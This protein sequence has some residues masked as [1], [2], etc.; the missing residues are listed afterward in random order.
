[1]IKKNIRVS[2]PFE[3]KPVNT[4]IIKKRIDALDKTKSATLNDIPTKIL[5]EN[6]DIFSP[7]I[8]SIFNNS[9]ENSSFPNPLKLSDVTP[10]YKKD[11]K[12]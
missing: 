4:E 12:S 10:V 6:S 7:I 1:M 3:L 8:T 2:N 11:V 5:I 9:I